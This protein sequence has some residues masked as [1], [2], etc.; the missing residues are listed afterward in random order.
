MGQ[1]IVTSDEIVEKNLLQNTID[2]YTALIV[3]IDK[4]NT[5]LNANAKAFSEVATAANIKSKKSLNDLAAAYA[6]AKNAVDQSIKNDKAKIDAT[7]Q[8]AKTQLD[9]IKIQ[10]AQ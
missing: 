9:A 7:N 5:E 2:Q 10:K 6:K 8:L 1:G 4:A 3:Q